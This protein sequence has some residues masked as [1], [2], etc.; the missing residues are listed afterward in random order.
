MAKDPAKAAA[1]MT[2]TPTAKA[3][4]IAIAM[5]AGK[6]ATV[7]SGLDVVMTAIKSA[8]GAPMSNETRA[9]TAPKK[10]IATKARIPIVIA[11]TTINK[12]TA[13]RTAATTISKLTAVGTAAITINNSIA[14]GK[15]AIAATIDN[16]SIN[17]N[18]EASV[19]VAVAAAV[20]AV[21]SA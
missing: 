1:E 17:A 5:A 20:G 13:V 14:I 10:T 15:T 4:C 8:T 11:A 3:M 6:S 16:S 19:V 21:K 18:K 7:T 12:L 2:S 9:Q